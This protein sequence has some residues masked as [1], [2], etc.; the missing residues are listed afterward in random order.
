MCTITIGSVVGTTMG[1]ALT[2]ITVTGTATDCAAVVVTIQCP[3]QKVTKQFPVSG[4]SFTAVF[5]AAALRPSECYC[6]GKIQ[7]VVTCATDASCFDSLSGQLECEGADC[8]DVLVSAVPDPECEGGK[9]TVTLNAA[10]FGGGSPS[11]QWSYGDLTSGAPFV[12][13]PG[14]HSETHD[15]PPG[16]Y[17]ATLNIAGCPSQTVAIDVECPPHG[18]CPDI[19]I[20]ASP[21]TNACTG[22]KMDVALNA[23]NPGSETVAEWDFGDAV[24]A[25][26]TLPAG[27]GT[28]LHHD[29]APGTYTVTLTP[30]GCPPLQVTF[31][32]PECPCPAFTVWADPDISACAGGKMDVALNAANPGSGVMT[33]SW[34]FGDSGGAGVSLPPGGTTIHHD[35]AAPGTYTATLHVKGCASLPVKFTLP[36]CPGT[37]DRPEEP[38]G[39]DDGGDGG[40]DGSLCG[41][42]CIA[43][44]LLAA[45]GLVAIALAWPAPVIAALHGLLAIVIIVYV[46]NCGPCSLPYCLLAGVALFVI[47]VIIFLFTQVAMPG[48]GAALIEA[49]LIVVA[50][51]IGLA[52]CASRRRRG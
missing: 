43:V 37:P 16:S 30:K 11:A 36:E 10:A 24:A 46:I 27:G 47:T 23:F 42:L 21:D 12:L 29:Y 39:G 51:L 33:G 44:A 4:G 26:V 13:S 17:T 2:K 32:V 35:Y 18:G 20:W 8:P 9:L 28:T 6:R 25:G 38:G 52:L 3:G 40:G 7:V 14:I 48:V 22:G 31:T 1:G 41:L 19:V 5:D 49:A 34:D 50:A 15:Y 45:M